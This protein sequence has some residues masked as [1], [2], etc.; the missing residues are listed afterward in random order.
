MKIMF[1]C[2]AAAAFGAVALGGAPVAGADP[3]GDFL[4][5]I[6]DGGITWPSDK[7]AQVI[8]TGYAVCQDWAAG[9]TFEQEVA[10]LTS[11][12]AWSDYQAGYFIG[13]A[14]GA[15]CPEYEDRI[16]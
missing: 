16:G 7:T 15:F 3:E 5:V 1:A 6:S 11:A 14:T 13:A 8:E 2:A 12:T 10:D 9:V 4:T